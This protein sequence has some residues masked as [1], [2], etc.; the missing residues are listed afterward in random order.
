MDLSTS[1]AGLNLRSPLIVGASS[2]TSKPENVKQCE[3]FGAGAVVLKSLYEEQITADKARL[4]NQEDMY[5]WYPDAATYIDNHAREQGLNKYMKLVEHCK[6]EVD[7]PVI[8]SINCVSSGSW[9]DFV[10]SIEKAGADALELN[11]FIPPTNPEVT[12]EEIENNYLAILKS[13]KTKVNIPITL[14]PG[15]YFTN[16]S[17]IIKL[18]D[19]AGAD[20]MALFNRYF[21][22]DVDI[23]NMQ[24]I[25][26]NVLSDPH[27]ITMV[28]RWIALMSGKVKADLC[29][30]MG[31]H[32]TEGVIKHILCGASAVQTVSVLYEKGIEHLQEMTDGLVHWMTD[33][34]YSKVSD[35]KGIITELEEGKASFERVHFMQKSLGAFV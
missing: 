25:T 24:V 16:P 15:F 10:T 5:F 6:N 34:K 9:L 14:K 20:G 3:K 26:S 2:L 7:I 21:R 27:E 28:L 30:T 35:F 13:V 29:A 12:G 17:R 33:K 8:A 32:N 1:Y 11:I 23:E 22:P 19:D 4:D 18:M 31:I